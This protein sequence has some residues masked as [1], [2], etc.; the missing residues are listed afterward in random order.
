MEDIKAYIESG[1]LELYVLG[2]VTPAERL[3]VE[4]MAAKHPA[5]KAELVEIERAMELY[6]GENEVEPNEDLRNRVLNSLVINLADDR[7]FP[8]SKSE[9]EAGIVSITRPARTNF[10]KYA[11]A[12][13]FVLL[14]VSV[15]ALINAYHQIDASNNLIASL[16]NQNQHFT[17]R[18][19]LMDHELKVLQD[20]SFK[21]LRLQG[22]PKS[23]SSSL[24]VAWSPAKK[25]V[26]IDMN[27][28]NMPVNDKQHQYQ[29]WAL[30]SGKPVSLGVFD[31][32][33]T[34]KGM[35]EMKPT[36]Y[37]DAFAV[38][39]EPRGGSQSPTM[40]EMMAIGKF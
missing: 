26:M 37:A 39:L 34:S 40:D 10:Y 38:T 33:S 23:P 18:V 15:V 35:V 31:A 12:A 4:A 32:D 1:I 20:P 21:M 6:A 22:T 14:I 30:V 24:M 27:D 13:C 9:N 29:L 5:I 28:T 7:N 2:D 17:N 36:A 19:N 25:K 16:Q 3:Q 11:F 8:S